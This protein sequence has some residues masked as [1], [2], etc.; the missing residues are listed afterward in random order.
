MNEFF[1]GA[2][3]TV[4][5]QL[6]GLADMRPVDALSAV[7]I[8]ALVVAAIYIA[9]KI[10]GKLLKWALVAG[11]VLVIL[12]VFFNADPFGIVSHVSEITGWFSTG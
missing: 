4:S 11:V 3:D 10:V 1:Q 5:Y 6:R 7:V 2:A 9:L 12:A 8:L